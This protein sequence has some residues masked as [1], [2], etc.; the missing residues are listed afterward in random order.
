MLKRFTVCCGSLVN[1]SLPTQGGVC[2]DLSKMDQVVEV[3]AKDFYAS[4]QPGVTRLA[5]NNYLR[6][7]GLWFPVGELWAELSLTINDII[8]A[9]Q[10]FPFPPTYCISAQVVLQAHTRQTI[11]ALLLAESWCC[12]SPPPPPP[13][14]PTDPGADAS[15]CGMAATSASG[16]NAVRCTHTSPSLPEPHNIPH[17]FITMYIPAHPLSSDVRVQYCYN[18][19]HKYIIYYIIIIIVPTPFIFYLLSVVVFKFLWPICNKNLFIIHDFQ[20]YSSLSSCL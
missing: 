2:V 17:V 4:V 20:Q 8:I 10:I 9:L 18:I 19:I 1:V 6:D 13:P 7:T 16:T 3:Q 14:P 5:L 11:T 12:V 15:L